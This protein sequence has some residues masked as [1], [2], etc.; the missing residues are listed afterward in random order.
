MNAKMV[1]Q[2][3]KTD[4]QGAKFYKKASKTDKKAKIP[5]RW[6]DEAISPP[7]NAAAGKGSGGGR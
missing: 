1:V 7:R 5:P 6:A 3:A 2:S 4:V